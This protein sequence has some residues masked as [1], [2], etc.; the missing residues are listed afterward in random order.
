MAPFRLSINLNLPS[1]R[2]NMRIWANA[3]YFQLAA[4]AYNLFALQ[5]D[6]ITSMNRKRVITVR[7]QLYDIAAKVTW[8]ARRL[9]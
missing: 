3:L 2:F 1:T 9:I 6:V 8:H 4:L 7:R 5:R